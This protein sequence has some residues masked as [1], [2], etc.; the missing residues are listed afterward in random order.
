MRFVCL[1]GF[2]TAEVGAFSTIEMKY[3]W[4]RSLKPE[5]RHMAVVAGADIPFHMTT[6]IHVP[7][8]DSYTLDCPSCGKEVT[9]SSE[10]GAAVM[11]YVQEKY[12][13]W[14]V[15]QDLEDYLRLKARFE[16][17]DL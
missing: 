7:H 16:P 3:G 6:M 8:R 9:P 5:Y 10:F 12:K 15:A 2:E 17:G 4:E 11:E 13:A 14:K 1:C